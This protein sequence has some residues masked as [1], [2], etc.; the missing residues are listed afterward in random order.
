VTLSAPPRARGRGHPSTSAAS[1]PLET[2]VEAPA[3]SGAHRGGIGP[4]LRERYAG[5]LAIALR[6]DRPTLVANFVET[7]DGVVSLDPGRSGGAE[8]NGGNDADRF[9]RALLRALAD[10]VLVGSGTLRAS[11]S[12]ARTAAAIYPDAT[13]EFARLRQSIR[14]A[15]VPATLVA[16]G[17]GD[18][19]PRHPLFAD[20]SAG[21][22]VAGPRKALDRL[23]AAGIPGHV[24]LEPLASGDPRE[25]LAVASHLGAGLV[26]SEAGPHLAGELL[27][28][29]L[30][31]E[32]FVTV[33]PGLAGRS[34]ETPRLSLVEGA[35]MG[36]SPRWMGLLSARRSGSHLFLRYSAR[37]TNDA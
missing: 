30:V 16:T 15:P 12:G 29:G 6:H 32:L 8:V 7:I 26:V 24:R 34:P 20:P 11:G 22:V 2:L 37:S 9:V 33:S 19:D 1:A 14:L 10:V 4:S 13:A 23:R 5:D 35:A 21:A 25:L 3:T 36:S 27:A 17:R 18:L 31:D 28:A